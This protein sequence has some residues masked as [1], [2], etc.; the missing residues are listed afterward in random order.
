MDVI[1]LIGIIIAYLIGS[2]PSGFVIARMHN[3]RDIREH[4][5]G[6]IGATNVARVLGLKYFFIV[7]FLDFSKAYLCIRSLQ[8]YDFD[9]MY[10]LL[11]GIALLLGNSYPI[12]LQFRGGKGVATVCGILLALNPY[13]ILYSLFIWLAVAI[14]TKTIGKASIAA[15]CCAPFIS[16]YILRDSYW[17]FIA[18]C[19]ISLFGL[20]RHRTNMMLYYQQAWR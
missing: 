4:G 9:V 12:F 11:A 8:F 2:I 17:M 19:L 1:N 7:L 3:I 13:L 16:A 5:S 10:Q 14:T 20:L 6:N 18:V 15:F